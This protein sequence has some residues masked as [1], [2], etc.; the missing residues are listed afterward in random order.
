MQFGSFLGLDAGA[1]AGI[2]VAVVLAA[3][4]ALLYALG[5]LRP[6][7]VRATARTLP[8]EGGGRM[9]EVVVVIRSR[10]RNTQTVSEVALA[11]WPP[12][13]DRV[14]HPR[15][16]TKHPFDVQPFDWKSLTTEEQ[17]R[18]EVPGH[19][20]RKLSGQISSYPPFSST[21]VMVKGPRKRP[22]IKRIKQ[23]P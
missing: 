11:R 22:L 9:T 10:T 3:V 8:H 7:A 14:V 17:R 16:R 1:I 5:T 23:L 12:Y 18:L 15:W 6:L 21:R 20:Q 4:P 2:I 19:D 13:W